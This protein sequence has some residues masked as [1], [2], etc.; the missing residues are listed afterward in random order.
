[1]NVKI[2]DWEVIWEGSLAEAAEYNPGA[3]VSGFLG[4]Y[5]VNLSGSPSD[6]YDE[7]DSSIFEGW[8]DTAMAASAGYHAYANADSFHMRV[9]YGVVH[10]LM[11]RCR[12]NETDV[13][14]GVKFIDAWCRVNITVTSNGGYTISGA[15]SGDRYVSNNETDHTFLWCNFVWDNTGAGYTMT[16]NTHDPALSYYWYN[17]TSISIQVYK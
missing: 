16:K 9:K 3:G 4:F 15:I 7:N 8:A 14:D 10:S 11:V 1:M 12:F 6:A 17:V 2:K 5:L 13:G